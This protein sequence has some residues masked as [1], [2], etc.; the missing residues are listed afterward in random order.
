MLQ[1][2]EESYYVSAA[3]IYVIT[4][5]R[6]WCSKMRCFLS[7]SFGV[8]RFIVSVLRNISFVFTGEAISVIRDSVLENY[9]SYSSHYHLRKHFISWR[10]QC[11]WDSLYWDFNRTKNFNQPSNYHTCRTTSPWSSNINHYLSAMNWPHAVKWFF[12]LAS[13]IHGCLDE[14]SV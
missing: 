14:W 10:F 13:S 11:I 6:L 9:E 3:D 2:Y 5:N 1:I 4:T 7:R 8:D 12:F